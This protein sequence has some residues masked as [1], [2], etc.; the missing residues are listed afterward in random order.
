MTGLEY[1]MM[2]A[3][4]ALLIIAG[5]SLIGQSTSRTMCGTA[6]VLNGAADKLGANSVA[7]APPDP[8]SP[9]C[10]DILQNNPS[11]QSG[12]YTLYVAGTSIQAY[13]DM[14]TDGGGWT[15]VMRGNGGDAVAGPAINESYVSTW[16]TATGALNVTTSPSPTGSSFKYSD[17][18]INALQK[19]G[20][21]RLISDGSYSQKR[22]VSNCTY[23][24]IA[25]ASGNC[26]T[27]YSNITFNLNQ[28]TGNGGNVYEGFSDYI[29]GSGPI[30]FPLPK[31]FM[32]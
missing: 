27:S 25:T 17:K 10:W 20:M 18:V 24:H 1:A 12:I 31:E 8:C 22:F 11:A 4:L 32:I 6:G 30:K 7:G 23:S 16:N 29:L 14:T 3:I 26:Q 19:N 15:L 2:A 13:C 28:Q 5:A 21:L 9:S